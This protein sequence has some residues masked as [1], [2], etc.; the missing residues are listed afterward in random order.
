[1]RINTKAFGLTFG[2]LRGGTI[3]LVA[4]ANLIW[5]D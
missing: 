5:S 2:I 3:L 1:M 4:I